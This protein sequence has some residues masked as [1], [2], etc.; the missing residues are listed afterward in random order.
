MSLGLFGVKRP[1]DVQPSDI[2]VIVIYKQSRDINSDTT[3]TK[4]LGTDVISP[5]FSNEDIG[6]SDIEILGGL[7]N[8]TLPND[9]FNEKGFYTVYIRPSQI[10]VKI[11]DCADLAT[12]P[13]VKGLVFDIN[14][15]PSE[16]V[17]K[18][19]NNGLDGYRI[20]FLNDD[21]TKQSNVYRL[22]TSSFVCEPVQVTVPNTTQKAI[23]YIYSNVGS[24][25]FCTVTP[26]SAPSFRPSSKPFIGRKDQNVIITNTSFNP[27]VFEIEMVNYD[28][29]SLAIS[30]LGEQSKSIDDGIYTL[31]DFNGN[32]YKQYDLYEVR[33]SLGEKLYEVRRER[34]NIDQTKALNNIPG[35]E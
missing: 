13:D 14:S 31:Y 15:V 9:I 3:I 23:K 8:L 19:T 32:I 28:V 35:N 29:E 10:R 20:E 30:L 6:G 11:E 5:V 1:A 24:L 21:G 2:E 18:F 27:Q 4:L 17:S 33:N 25:L 12:F 26:N 34:T 22:I 16:F 7:Y